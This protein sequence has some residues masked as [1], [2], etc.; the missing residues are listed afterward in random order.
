MKTVISIIVAFFLF[1]G[2]TCTGYSQEAPESRTDVPRFG[3]MRP[4]QATRLKWAREFERAPQAYIDHAIKGR[5]MKA[6]AKRASTSMSLLEYLPYTASERNQNQC[7]N[8]WVWAGTGVLEIADGVQRAIEERRSIQFLNSCKTDGFACNGGTLGGFVD[9]YMAQGYSIPWSNVNASFQDG[10]RSCD[11]GS[12]TCSTNVSCDSITKSPSYPIPV[13]G[14]ET[15]YT[16]NISDTT[17]MNNIKN[18]L[19]QKKAVEFDFCLSTHDDWTSFNYFWFYKKESDLWNPDAFCGE[20]LASGSGCH[21]VLVV[22]YNDDDPA[23]AKHYWIVVNSWGS[24]SDRPNGI[25]RMPMHMN[26]SCTQHDSQ[27]TYMSRSF[28]TLDTGA[29]SIL[30]VTRSGNGTGSVTSDPAGIDCGNTCQYGFATDTVVTLAATP[31]ADSNFAGWTGAGCS[32]AG[33]CTVTMDRKASVAASFTPKC[34]YHLPVTSLTFGPAGAT[35]TVD[36]SVENAKCPPPPVTPNADWITPT[37]KWNSAKGTGIISVKA[38]AKTDTYL[39]RDGG[40]AVQKDGISVHQN[41]TPCA[42]GALVP[43]QA[44]FARGEHD[45][46]AFKVTATPSDCHWTAV[47]PDASWLLVQYAMGTGSGTVSYNV[48]ANSSL[49]PR[50][51]K[52]RVSLTSS[53]KVFKGFTVTQTAR[54]E[55]PVKK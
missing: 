39:G 41:G 30:T 32:G 36:V 18:V 35:K 2:F 16:H 13:V 5:L 43:A 20:A 21:A 44:T 11:S 37:L 46:Q 8:C 10:S 27:H 31:A 42:L 9:W 52:I 45:G 26:Y 19:H 24:T 1:V 15:I 14:M 38:A 34:V 33:T 23:L 51:G 17:A 47:A 3:I 6:A 28:S 53:S 48:M 29:N 22:G 40:V 7:G 4:D 12:T 50:T 25:F 49:S 54:P 55:P